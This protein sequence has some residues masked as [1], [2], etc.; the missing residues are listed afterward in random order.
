MPFL[1]HIWHFLYIH[2]VFIAAI[3]NSSK[4]KKGNSVFP[5]ETAC[6]STACYTDTYTPFPD[7]SPVSASLSQSQYLLLFFFLLN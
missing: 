7:D 3:S 6:N 1:I 4:M 5:A 2:E